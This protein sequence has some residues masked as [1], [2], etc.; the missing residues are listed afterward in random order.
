VRVQW[1]PDRL[2]GI[3]P[4]RPRRARPLLERMVD[5]W[6]ASRELDFLPFDGC[7]PPTVDRPRAGSGAAP[8]HLP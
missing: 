2:R 4:L 1:I 8:R 3:E 7:R 6:F 5:E